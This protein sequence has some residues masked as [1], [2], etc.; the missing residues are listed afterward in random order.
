MSRPAR[1]AWSQAAR[2]VVLTVATLLALPL[3][4]ASFS[5]QEGQEGQEVTTPGQ[6]PPWEELLAAPPGAPNPEALRVLVPESPELAHRLRILYWEGSEGQARRTADVLARNPDL[7]GLPVG[8]PE[9]VVVVLAPD[10]VAW[11]AFTGGQ[12][13]HWGAGV[14]IPARRRIV[15]PLFRAPWSGGIAEDRTLRHEW[16]HLGLHGYLEGLRIPRWFDEG[17]AQWA[18]GG[19]DAASAWRLRVALARGSDTPL[20]ELTLAWPR[21]RADAELAYL[22]SASAVGFMASEGGAAGVALL[23]RRWREGGTFDGAL[24]STYGVTASGFEDRWAEHVR[25]RY[26]WLV[27]LTQT[28]FIWGVLG[29]G[30]VVLFA[31]RRRRDRDHLDRLRQGE[32]GPG[33]VGPWWRPFPP[34]RGPEVPPAASPPVDPRS[35]ER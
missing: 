19:W 20:S 21:A 1:S 12:A 14:A 7:P 22:L 29:V 28:G 24:R 15:M 8:V 34:R 31:I 10:L 17:Y 25:D 30:I 4:A 23:L 3:P 2:A 9:R 32:P 5:G 6:L 27:F 13:P 11:D 33:G 18:S 26:G 35:P 16:A